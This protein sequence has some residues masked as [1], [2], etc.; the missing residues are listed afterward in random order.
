MF[1]L[2]PDDSTHFGFAMCGAITPVPV[3]AA[4]AQEFAA[5]KREIDNSAQVK[6]LASRLGL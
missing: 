4:L 6:A 2:V 5:A 1:D 3:D